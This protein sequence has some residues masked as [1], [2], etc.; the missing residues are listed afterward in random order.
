MNIKTIL[1]QYINYLK[2]FPLFLIAL[3][4]IANSEYLAQDKIIERIILVGD[5]GDPEPTFEEP[6][7]T[8]LKKFNEGLADITTLVFLG[9]NI[10]PIGL[11]DENNP[12]RKEYERRIS[13]QINSAK[14][15]S[16]QAFFI[17]GN[18]DWNKGS[19][20]GIEYLKRQ[21]NFISQNSDEKVFFK[22][23]AGC[24]GP[25]YID[26]NDSIRIIFI[27]SQWWLQDRNSEISA[28]ENCTERNEEEI[29]L[30]VNSLLSE[31]DIKYIIISAHHPLKTYG[32]HGGFFSITSHI[33][34]LRIFNKNLWIPLPLIGSMY[35]L[36]RMNGYTR[37]DVSNCYYQ[38]YISKMES[39]I[40]SHPDK[41]II[42][43]SGH[44]H[45]IQIIKETNEI[46]YL[47]SG[48]GIYRLHSEH[49]SENENLIYRG[50]HSGFIVLD[51]LRDG[52]VE[53]KTIKVLNEKGEYTI[54]FSYNIN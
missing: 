45:T 52:S 4:I 44:E 31:N 30:K 35:P 12:N 17:A 9:D 27:D 3:F 16:K 22:P 19:D 36:L 51:F 6:V 47:I 50:V 32:E 28:S 13:V 11:T 15:N 39:V 43:A 46:L 25:E 20:D 42:Y 1:T 38:N 26:L 54:S 24:P 8:A 14:E 23:K 48:A 5:A 40:K 49:L 29:T 2:K 53:L 10:Y 34:P 41:K 7:F 37:Q 21:Q 33:F 18:H